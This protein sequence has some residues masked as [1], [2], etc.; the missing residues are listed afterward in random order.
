MI[1]IKENATLTCDRATV[2]D[3]AIN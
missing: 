3:R 1:T 2:N